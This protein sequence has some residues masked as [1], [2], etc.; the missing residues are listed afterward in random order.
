M[1]GKGNTFWGG[2]EKQ[3][4]LELRWRRAADGSRGGVQSP[5]THDRQQWTAVYVRSLA[6]RMTTTGNGGGWKRLVRCMK[7]AINNSRFVNANA[8]IK[9]PL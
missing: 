7:A 3:S 6:A 2:Y 9:F 4:A 8:A 5:E 1:I